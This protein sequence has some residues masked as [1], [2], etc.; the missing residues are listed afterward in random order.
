MFIYAFVCCG[1]MVDRED[2]EKYLV[3]Y[4]G[5]DWLSARV[6]NSNK[7]LFMVYY[8]PGDRTY[9]LFRRFFLEAA[10]EHHR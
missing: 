7:P 2:R 3:K 10:K 4:E 5:E 6:K 1:L 9:L 8:S